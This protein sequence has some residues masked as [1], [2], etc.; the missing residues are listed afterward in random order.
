MKSWLIIWTAI[1]HNVSAFAQSTTAMATIKGGTYVPLYSSDTAA[2]QVEPFQLD[3]YPVSNH[4]FLE[5]VLRNGSWQKGRVK[6]LFADSS[7]L[8]YWNN[9]IQL[10]KDS[11]MLAN[12]PVVYISWYAAKTYCECQG[13]RLPTVAE[14]EFAAMASEK[15]TNATLDSGFNQRIIDWY[16]KPS[17]KRAIKQIGSTFQ[18]IYGVWDMHGLIWEWTQDF[19]SALTSGESRSDASLDKDLFCGAGAVNAKNLKNYAAFMRN[20]MRASL[21][22]RYTVSNLGFR[23][24]KTIIKH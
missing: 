2:M 6:S 3:I 5:F 10:G 14:W 22:A 12:A 11:A 9:A 20:A 16:A 18:N 1:L 21:K 13:K 17:P 4:Q 7:Y 19:N 23:C 15:K 24:A 8:K